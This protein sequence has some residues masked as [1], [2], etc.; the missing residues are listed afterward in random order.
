MFTDIELDSYFES[1]DLHRKGREFVRTVRVS[2]PSRSVTEG[3]YQNVTSLIYSEKMGFTIQSD[4]STGE[5]SAVY[6]YEM[7]N[8]VLE[9]WDQLPPTKIKGLNKHGKSAA[10]SV[11]PDFLVLHHNCVEV[12]EIKADSFIDK[13][14][15]SG[16]P[17]WGRD[18][19]G[20]IH[21]FPA[22]KYFSDIGIKYR[23]RPISSFNKTL[24]SNQKLLL[25]SRR[26]KPPCSRLTSAVMELLTKR[27]SL[28]M[29]VLLEELGVVNAVPI[30]QMI[31]LG[32]IHCELEREFLSDNENVH[33]AL[34]PELLVHA[35][36]VRAQ[37]E[38]MR[39][40][41]N[42]KIGDVPDLKS[43]KEALRRLKIIEEDGA[44]STVRA[45]KKKI[46]DGAS[47]GLSA[48]ESL[49]PKTN[50]RGNRKAKVSDNVLSIFQ[51]SVDLFYAN[52]SRSSVK[53]AYVRYKNLARIKLPDEDPISEK[54]Y[55]NRIRQL[56]QMKLG[57]ERGGKRMMYANSPTSNVLDRSL[58]S[59]VAFQ[60]AH[61]DHH[62]VKCFI[63]W[64]KDGK[65]DF[66][67]RPWLTLLID[68]ADD[69]V[70]GYHYSFAKPS[71][72]A[73]GCV[74]R[75]CVRRYGKL[76][77]EIV[78]DHGS[79]FKSVYLRSLLASEKVTLTFRPKS[80]S[81]SGSE[82][83]RFFNEFQTQ[84]LCQRDG[85]M[86]DKYAARSVDGKFA[87]RRM[88][89]FQPVDLL[90]EF[91]Q[92][93][94]HRDNKLRGVKTETAEMSFN[95]D[96]QTY[97]FV[98]KAVVYDERFIVASAVETDD[99]T[100][101]RNDI[102]I[103]GI[104]YSH[105]DL[106]KVSNKRTKVEVRVEPENPY[107]V[108]AF[109]NDHWVSCVATGAVEFM[110]KSIINQKVETLKIRGAG[111]LRILAQQTAQDR[112]AELLSRAD[113]SLNGSLRSGWIDEDELEPVEESGISISV[114]DELATNELAQL[115]TAYW[116]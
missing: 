47:Q 96:L 77:E 109:I 78:A 6:G 111:S 100:I 57:F 105:P 101:E 53:S 94:A 54:T 18:D 14:L 12:H 27:F 19:T 64:G 29:Q 55:R 26:E 67:A 30:I 60:R 9:F 106:R 102:K 2:D 70:I 68:E 73:D 17:S 52:P 37:S 95:A 49:L 41:L 85:N 23:I 80:H 71:R 115:S 8:N 39:N 7:D 15:R 40:I 62:L 24:L 74:L 110:E 1:I 4:S 43:T 50:L 76:P 63:V 59:R 113:E 46:K 28:T 33:V 88:A 66:V 83:E 45:W 10:W 89:V 51:E 103:D 38:K 25:S 11:R 42:I 99:Y 69:K 90:R 112:L 75:D 98:G 32:V 86:V 16:H 91:E 34:T 107:V 5:Y 87:S 22:E 116:R 84:W 93:L 65:V 48:F 61:I 79:D 3:C 44:S 36:S 104:R 82:V 35:R 81:K 21:Y 56:N 31:D 92:Y 114:F 58:K 13:Q 72:R 108:Y 20:K 97:G